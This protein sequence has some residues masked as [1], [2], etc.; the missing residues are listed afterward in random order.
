MTNRVLSIAIGN[1]HTRV[2]ELFYLKFGTVHKGVQVYRSITFQNPDN[3]VDDG[4][5]KNVRL[6]GEELSRQL[7]E[8]KFKAD[9]VIFS[10]SSGRI[11]SREISLPP[12]KEKSIMEIIKTG[13]SEYFPIDISDYILS[14][15]IVEKSSTVGLQKYFKELSD[16]IIRSLRKAEAKKAVPVLEQ[17][18]K[19]DTTEAGREQQAV[20]AEGEAVEG[21]ERETVTRQEQ[22]DNK[23]EKRNIR[24]CVYAA[25]S[26]LV[27]SYYELAKQLRMDIVSLDYSGNSSYQ[28][29]R[30][31]ADKGTNI[32]VQMNDKDTLVSILKD[33]ILI[34][35]RN[36]GYGI[37]MLL[38]ALLTQSYYKISSRE[39]ALKLLESTNLFA[40]HAGSRNEDMSAISA[41]DEAAAADEL[42]QGN[43]LKKLNKQERKAREIIVE[44]M[45]YLTGSVARM[46]DY[47]KSNHKDEQPD[48]IFITGSGIRI[49]GIEDFF[50]S[51]IGLASS[52]L[53]KLTYANGKKT[54]EQFSSYQGEYI[55]CIGA[56]LSPV[57]F[58]PKEMVNKKQTRSL[59]FA[60]SL[61]S[62]LCIAGSAI[63]IYVARSDYND[64]QKELTELERKIA[65][66]PD[67]TDIYLQY[68][69]TVKEQQSYESFKAQLET[70]N[71]QINNVILEL[72]DKLPAGTRVNSVQF[73][74]SGVNMSV[75]ATIDSSGV[76]VLLAKIY[77]ELEKVAYFDTIDISN[78]V[79]VD[80]NVIPNTASFTI[81]CTYID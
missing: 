6:Y 77:T 80:A 30:R 72:E 60:I 44:A 37:N 65:A 15:L 70:N 11:A 56:I 9:R 13:A 40:E 42:T 18:D 24:V 74:E 58:V 8:G 47:Y 17:E 4:Y 1:E 26:S 41:D 71:D 52:K 79:T 61:I 34:L 50:S 38:D 14:Y 33:D 22:K 45:Q 39:E 81:S 28:L 59:I 69:Q 53:N 3:T 64:A 10:V 55:S 63:M 67:L 32:Y 35:Q 27:D 76:Y 20:N 36:I 5:I 68:D 25:P 19:A 12:V 54:A 62:F 23:Q 48:A 21:T 49:Q 78:S 43:S 7:K 2:C 51:E 73:N 75:T 46:I 16:N 57:D 66:L 29:I 31:Q